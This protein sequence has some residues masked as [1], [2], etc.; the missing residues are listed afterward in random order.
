MSEHE[1]YWRGFQ[2]LAVNYEALFVFPDK[3]WEWDDQKGTVFGMA[4]HLHNFETN[5]HLTYVD[6]GKGARVSPMI[7]PSRRNL[8][9]LQLHLLAET[10]WVRPVPQKARLSKLDNMDVDVVEVRVNELPDESRKVEFCLDRKSHLPVQIVYFSTR[11][12]REL[13]GGIRLSRYVEIDGIKIPEQIG[14]RRTTSKLNV[15]YD[16][17]VF[18]RPPNISA[19]IDA[20]KRKE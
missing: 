9:Q 18:E 13:S 15:A 2:R 17:R 14:R 10:R 3:S 16:S 7:N 5:T 4:I 11:N 20:W 1:K 8:V 19:G 12:G 6:A